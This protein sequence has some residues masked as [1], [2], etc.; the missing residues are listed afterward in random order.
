MKGDK[1]ELG[2]PGFDVGFDVLGVANCTNQFVFREKTE[3]KAKPGYRGQSVPKAKTDA[4][5]ILVFLEKPGPLDFRVCKVIYLCGLLPTG[6]ELHFVY[7]N[8]CINTLIMANY[9]LNCLCL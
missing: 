2:M 6:S 4:M 3:T 8:A 7:I 5:G 1:G 9:N